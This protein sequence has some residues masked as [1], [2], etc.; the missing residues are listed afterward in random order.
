M[1]GKE[2]LLAEYGAEGSTGIQ[3]NPTQE[4]LLGALVAGTD[5][6]FVQESVAAVNVL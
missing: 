3:N 6:G 1:Q 2:N 5:K 4:V